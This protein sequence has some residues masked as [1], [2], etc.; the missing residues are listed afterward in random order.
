MLV[1]QAITR[2]GTYT[3]PS[4]SHFSTRCC[5]VGSEDCSKF[6]RSGTY[7]LPSKSRFSTRCSPVGSEDCSK[8]IC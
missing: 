3:L 5:P 1:M 6:T 8:F 7:T 2:S 4:K